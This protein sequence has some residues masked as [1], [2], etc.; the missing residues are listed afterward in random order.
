MAAK[1]RFRPGTASREE[2]FLLDF[3]AKC[4][5]GDFYLRDRSLFFSLIM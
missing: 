4:A 2:P 5:F 3:S 1:A